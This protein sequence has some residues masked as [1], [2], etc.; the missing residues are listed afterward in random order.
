M[1]VSTDFCL[2]TLLFASDR[3]S[4]FLQQCLHILFESLFLVNEVL[5]TYSHDLNVFG[6][7]LGCTVVFL[8]FFVD[9]IVFIEAFR[10]NDLLFFDIIYCFDSCQKYIFFFEFY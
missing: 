7:A 2:I 1:Q 10:V 9:V 6:H 5:P 8:G 3:R 4:L